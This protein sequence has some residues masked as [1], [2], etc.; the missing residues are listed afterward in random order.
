LRE[1][2]LFFLLG[3]LGNNFLLGCKKKKYIGKKTAPAKGGGCSK[4][5]F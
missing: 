4:N 5:L 1:F 3:F 2:A